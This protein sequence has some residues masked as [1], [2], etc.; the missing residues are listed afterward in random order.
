MGNRMSALVIL[1]DTSGSITLQAPAAAGS[2]VQT[3]PAATGTVMVSGNMPAFHAWNNSSFSSSGTVNTKMVFDSTNSSGGGFDTNNNYSTANSR[4]TP[5]VAGYYQIGGSIW[6]G[7]PSQNTILS[8][9]KNGSLFKELNRLNYSTG[10]L[11]MNG[12]VLVYANGTTDYFE[13]YSYTT[14]TTTIGG[15]GNNAYL[16]FYG[17]MMRA[18]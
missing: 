14:N 12:S 2:S 4:F 3:L 9:Y 1:G 5:T 13:L 16:W 18:A 11:G 10:A 6:V 8:L 7:S 15:S 17:S